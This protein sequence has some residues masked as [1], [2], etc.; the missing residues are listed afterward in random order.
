MKI[1]AVRGAN[2]ASLAGEFEIDFTK[3]PLADSGIFAITGRT[4]SGKSTLLDAISLA[5]YNKIARTNKLEKV[6]HNAAAGSSLPP[7][8]DVRTILR[9]GAGDGFAEV[10]FIGLEKKQYRAKWQVRRARKKASGNL[11]EV[12]MSLQDLASGKQIG[13]KR[14]ETLEEIKKSIGLDFEQ[15]SRT[16]ILSQGEFDAFLK[17]RESERSLLLEALT[18]TSIYSRISREVNRRAR[19][20][21]N[22]L[23]EIKIQLGENRPLTLEERKEAE[24]SERLLKNRVAEIKKT[25]ARLLR[26]QEWYQQQSLLQDKIETA[27]TELDTAKKEQEQSQPQKENL[28]LVIKA[29]TL[30]PDHQAVVQGLKKQAQLKIDLKKLQEELGRAAKEG[31]RNQTA[32]EQAVLHLQNSKKDLANNR[33]ELK[34]AT[35]LDT[36]LSDSARSLEQVSA[37]VSSTQE[38]LLTVAEGEKKLLEEQ[39][40]IKERNR[41]KELWLLENQHLQILED[42]SD[43]IEQD[44][45][46][47]TSI[48]SKICDID[49]ET[50]GSESELKLLDEK[51]IQL[52]SDKKIVLAAI[53]QDSEQQATLQKQIAAAPN[54]L[55]L[56]EQQQNSSSQSHELSQLLAT[57]E[58]FINNSEKITR[59][60]KSAEIN[61]QEIEQLNSSKIETE[62]QLGKTAIQLEEARQGYQLAQAT[63]SDAAL[64][65]R[66]LLTDDS[67]C[68]VCGAFEHPL[69]GQ[70]DQFTILAKAQKER[71]DMLVEQE[72]QLRRQQEQLIKDLQKNQSEQQHHEQSI[73][74]LSKEQN[75]LS[76]QWL[77]LELADSNGL[78]KKLRLGKQPQ[79]QETIK[80]ALALAQNQMQ[81][82]S[83]RLKAVYADREKSQRL[84]QAIN[85][86]RELNSQIEKKI[87]SHQ[88]QIASVEQR[89]ATAA[90]AK[91][92]HQEH[93]QNLKQRLDNYN[94]L[95]PN[96]QQ[97]ISTDPAAVID[98]CKQKK[99]L[100]LA[101]KATT[102]AA[103]DSLE[104]NIKALQTIKENLLVERSA[105]QECKTRQIEAQKQLNTMKKE[106]LKLLNGEKCQDVQSRLDGAISRAENQQQE[107]LKVKNQNQADIDRLKGGEEAIKQQLEQAERDVRSNQK[108]LDEKCKKRQISM[109]ELVQ[110][111]NWSEEQIEAEAKKLDQIREAVTLK[112]QY[113]EYQQKALSDLN[114]Q[115]RPSLELEQLKKCSQQQQSLLDQEEVELAKAQGIIHHDNQ[116]RQRATTLLT[117]LEKQQEQS[118]LWD[119]MNY[120]IGSSNGDK[121]RKFAQSITLDRLI[122]QANFHLTELTPRYR[123]QRAAQ[124]DLS[125]EV[126]DLEMGSEVRGIA[127]LS[128]GERFLTSLA[129][130]L[131]LAGMSSNRGIQVESLFIDEGFGALDETSLNMAISALEAL[132]ATGRVIGIISHIQALTERIGVQIQIQNQGG[133][134]SR[135]ELAVV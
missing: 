127:N 84:E 21:N 81:S 61:S 49:K 71:V 75:N 98:G 8:H 18:G 46:L 53:H 16:V 34:K 38:R 67:P 130:A 39:N 117:S 62:K 113:L 60:E 36:Q 111:L 41:E 77:A 55:T 118:S 9:S 54:L 17:A 74:T 20:E 35:A 124:G 76:Q 99:I 107:I 96:W 28:E 32:L 26:E 106:R 97:L 23:T 126:V 13:G 123:L 109:D 14:T 86:N 101:T 47:F 85:K 78:F 116:I 88:A 15:F 82:S 91:K 119:K 7:A 93:L 64:H 108:K 66:T 122:E 50:P 56:Q 29:Q 37:T 94:I 4:G 134:R 125:L 58:L 52:N 132:Q 69:K 51:I 105:L 133:G 83:A 45:L 131:G 25:L 115:N 27:K 57:A 48:N 1:L 33:E 92:I 89:I 120:L 80:N 100:W 19:E 95:V 65:L 72:R 2:L 79:Q 42:R 129:M 112:K 73:K 135:I 114:R 68:P 103:A 87:I 22:A 5:L 12:E 44:I 24:A 102:R 6:S 90:D 59:A 30:R 10:D 11:Q 40:I 63:A 121:F 31:L 3:Q 43:E 70:D 110:G 128:G 104:I